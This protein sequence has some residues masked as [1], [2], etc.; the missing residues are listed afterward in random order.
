[1]SFQGRDITGTADR[2]YLFPNGFASTGEHLYNGHNVR[3]TD[4]VVL[5]EG[6]FDVVAI[7]IAFDEEQDL[8]HIVPIGS[9]GKHLA[10]GQIAKFRTLAERGVKNV[11]I[12]WDGELEATKDAIRAGL[13]LIGLGFNVKIA[14]LPNGCDPNEISAANVRHVYYQRRR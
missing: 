4:T 14:S 1:M 11:V 5:G 2:K 12:M 13:K 6:V 9:F 3:G 8:R 7:K 10:L